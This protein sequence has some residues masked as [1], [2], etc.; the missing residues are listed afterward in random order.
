MFHVMVF[1]MLHCNQSCGLE[2]TFKSTRCFIAGGGRSVSRQ[3]TR[4]REKILIEMSM[5]AFTA[6]PSICVWTPRRYHRLGSAVYHTWQGYYCSDVGGEQ[7]LWWQMR[8][9]DQRKKIRPGEMKGCT[10]CMSEMNN[11][12][13]QDASQQLR[14]RF[15]LKL[16]KHSLKCRHKNCQTLNRT[17][18]L[19]NTDRQL[20]AN[21]C[22]GPLRPSD[23]LLNTPFQCGNADLI[24]FRSNACSP[25]LSGISVNTSSNLF[26]FHVTAYKH[27]STLHF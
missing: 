24:R 26:I 25:D 17:F 5:F 9:S 7:S 21:S 3:R 6:P 10:V 12:L 16:Q 15:E 8:R 23:K 27:A 19:N 1:N 13:L 18:H 4:P 11:C 22:K 20:R 14:G 2:E